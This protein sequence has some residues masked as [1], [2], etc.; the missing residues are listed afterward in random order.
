MITTAYLLE[1][2]ISLGV[3]RP[4]PERINTTMGISKI[5]PVPR[6]R[7]TIEER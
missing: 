3:S 5:I 6:V 1:L 4:N 7:V 2:R